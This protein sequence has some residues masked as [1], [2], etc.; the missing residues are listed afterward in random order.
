[1]LRVANSQVFVNYSKYSY[2]GNKRAFMNELVDEI[3]I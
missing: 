2:L 1:M 3:M